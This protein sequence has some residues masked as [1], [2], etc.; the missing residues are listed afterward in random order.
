MLFFIF[1]ALKKKV[2]NDVGLFKTFN[3]LGLS[4]NITS[5]YN[6]DFHFDL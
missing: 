4:L 3:P 5:I 6:Q 1:K 2:H